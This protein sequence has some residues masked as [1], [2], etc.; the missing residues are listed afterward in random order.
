MDFSLGIG[1]SLEMTKRPGEEFVDVLEKL[2]KRLNESGT[3][4]T[5]GLRDTMGADCSYYR[6]SLFM[7]LEKDFRE[8]ADLVDEAGVLLSSLQE[9][10][11]E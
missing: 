3:E 10:D 6:K 11:N 1:Y 2:R 7:F 8:L 5:V 4:R 9:D